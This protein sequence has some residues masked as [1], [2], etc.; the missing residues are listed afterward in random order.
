MKPQKKKHIYGSLD[1]VIK[2]DP[3]YRRDNYRDNRG[4]GE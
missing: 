1:A 2:Q 3:A 4:L